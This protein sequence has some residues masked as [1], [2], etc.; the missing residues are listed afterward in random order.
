MADLQPIPQW[1]MPFLGN[2]EK[3]REL[4]L[5]FNPVWLKWFI[6]TFQ[7]LIAGGLID[8]DSLAGLQGGNGVDQFWHLNAPGAAGTF[9]RSDGAAWANSTLTL[10]NTAAQGSLLYAATANNEAA[11][12][13]GLSG[14]FLQSNGTIPIWST[15]GFPTSVGAAGTFVR[16]NG[17]DWLASTVTIPDT[18]ASGSLP[19]ASSANVLSALAI[20]TSGKVLQSNGSIPGWS[21]PTFPTSVGAAGTILRSDGTNWTASTPT[22]PNTAASGTFPRG[23]GTNWV[24]STLTIPN[25]ASTGNL[26]YAS[27]ANTLAMLA[28]TATASFLDNSGASNIPAWTAKAALSRTDD[29]NVTLTLGGTPT[30]ALLAAT[31]LTLGWTGTLSVAR[32]GSG[33]GTYTPAVTDTSLVSGRVVLATTGGRLA[34]LSTITYSGGGVITATGFT[35]ALNGSLGGTT[36]S[37]AA[38][39]TLIASSLIRYDDGTQRLNIGWDGTDAYLQSIPSA[40]GA[41]NLAF[42]A[43]STKG[44][45]VTATGLKTNVN[46]FGFGSSVTQTNGAGALNGTL[47]NS[48]VTGNPTK[49]L[50]YDDNGTTRQVPAW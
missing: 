31:S 12:A 6:D 33:Q 47:T 19:Y 3:M 5:V 29:T 21:S 32:G 23:D 20:G 18:F 41:Q 46:T 48:P 17:T 10:P 15:A 16:S 14:R 13:I 34:D 25:A 49:W 43:G 44:G 22:Y 24:Q 26:P 11:L 36:P 2:E 30:T 27:A 9:P 45:R 28:T 8:H 35:G 50:A 1:A 38:V 7:Q 37:T 42:Y 40:G 4:E 39:T